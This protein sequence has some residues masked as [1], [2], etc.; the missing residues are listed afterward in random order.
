MAT[1]TSA[2]STFAISIANLYPSPQTIQGYAADDAFT[3]EAIEQAEIVMGV[4]GHMSA[5]FVFS[6]TRHTITIM[7]DSPSYAIF[8]KW[9]A[10]QA[11]A[12]EVYPAN[13]T[14]RLPATGY[15]YTLTNGILTTPKVAPDVRKV[16]QAIPF[17]ITWESIVAS[18][19]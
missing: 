1:I 9:Q 10:A 6:P 14:I 7:P 19:I 17:I 5:G 4:D 15:K 2:N 13:A 11:A 8:S 16:L 3:I 18:P 12:K